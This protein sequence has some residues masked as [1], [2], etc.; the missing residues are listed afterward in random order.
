M[1]NMIK[2]KLLF[3]RQYWAVERSPSIKLEMRGR[4]K[5]DLQL[6]K[7]KTAH[8]FL[9]STFTTLDPFNLFHIKIHAYPCLKVKPI[10]SSDFYFSATL[11]PS[12]SET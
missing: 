2:A 12:V 4:A 11:W 1:S 5:D 3:H 6:F 9:I 7:D 10:P 8:F